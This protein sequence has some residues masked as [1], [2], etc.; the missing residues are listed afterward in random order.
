M[1]YPYEKGEAERF[2]P[3]AFADM[4]NPPTFWLRTG[5]PREKRRQRRMMDE[6]G[7]RTHSEA[8][9]QAELLKGMA[10]LFSTDDYALWSGKVQ[11]YWAA[12][13]GFAE[14]YKDAK[15]DEVPEFVFEDEA[16]I[17]EVL[18]QIGKDWRPYRILV[19]DNREANRTIADV[20]N[21]CVIERY[22]NIDVP[23]DRMGKYI[24]LDCAMEV[25]D[26]L[27]Q[28]AHKAELDDNAANPRVE[29]NSKC[30]QKLFLTKDQE[31]NSELPQQSSP[32]QDDTKAG[33][34]SANGP[35]KAAAPSPKTPDPS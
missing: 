28:M 22:E 13:E 4:K 11:G 24:T 9:M 29:L 7:L 23:M 32:S 26:E 33:K 27:D 18:N 6:E 15:P 3:T 10:A 31:K 5:S 16:L 1:S 21:C 35:S 20:F 14:E 19:A 8:A 2:I 12:G 17:L 34:G 30:I 25:G